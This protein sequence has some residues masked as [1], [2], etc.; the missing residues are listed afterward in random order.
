MTTEQEKQREIDRLRATIEQECQTLTTG[1]HRHTGHARH[2][3]ISERMKIIGTST[4][5]LVVNKVTGDQVLR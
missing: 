1:L 5:E 2:G 3:Y 4:E